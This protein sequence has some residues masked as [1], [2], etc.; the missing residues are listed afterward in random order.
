[1]EYNTQE[2]YG[3]FKLGYVKNR[4]YKEELES[5]C[6]KPITMA[7][8]VEMSEHI[9][10]TDRYGSECDD[11]ADA[12]YIFVATG[13]NNIEGEELI[14]CFT[15]NRNGKGFEGIRW[16][17]IKEFSHEVELNNRFHIGSL[18]FQRKSM[19]DTFL[20]EIAEKALPEIWKYKH[21][22][23][24]VKCPILKSYIENVLIRLEKE[25]KVMY[26]KD[27]TKILFNTNLLDIYFNDI[28][29]YAEVK[30]NGE[31]WNPKIIEKGK[32]ER[33]KLGFGDEMPKAPKFFNDVNEVVFQTDLDIDVTNRDKLNHIIDERNSRFPEAYRGQSTS[34]LSEML[35]SAIKHAKAIAQRN[36]KFIVPM[37]RPQKNE[38]Q[39]L[40]PIYLNGRY[41]EKPDFSL[42][43]SLCEVD[44]KRFYRPETILGLEEAYQDARLIAKPDETWLNPDK[45]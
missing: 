7:D 16:L 3:L 5:L 32:E 15:R 22:R 41:E 6:G 27:K 45:I 44:G 9:A 12:Q 29:L 21:R 11:E 17:T 1:M 43:L 35:V 23:S 14:G 24:T 30:E 10:Y 40:M 34:F 13:C 8:I 42:V 19:A 33:M 37:Y 18:Y 28:L 20:G 36:Y 4:S 2:K 25:G 39:L 31:F 38:I 26:S